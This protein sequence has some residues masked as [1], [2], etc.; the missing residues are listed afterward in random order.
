MRLIFKK[1]NNK[2]ITLVEVLVTSIIMAF[3]L[4]GT[5]MFM[6]VNSRLNDEG[7]A[8][9]FLQTNLKSF[10]TQ[11]SNDV[12]NG[13]TIS[14]SNSD[15]TLTVEDKSGKKDVWTF[16]SENKKFIRNN[17]DLLVTGVDK[18]EYDCQFIKETVQ[19]ITVK[20]KL[21]VSKGANIKATTGDDYIVYRF[22]CRNINYEDS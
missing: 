20:L 3:V 8:E 6:Q 10:L 14:L 19:T 12:R 2:G 11:F 16:D 9:A 5:S 22:N 15:K 21:V 1:K 13:C 17:T 7:I 4:T 18:A